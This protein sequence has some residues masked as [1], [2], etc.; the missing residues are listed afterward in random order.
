MSAPVETRTFFVELDGVRRFLEI[1]W[2]GPE[3]GTVAGLVGS[4]G[5]VQEKAFRT[6]AKR[7]AWIATRIAKAK[8]EGLRRGFTGSASNPRIPG[9]GSGSERV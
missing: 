7:D 3:V 2:T 6:L 9:A 8:K 4:K 1:S 5:R